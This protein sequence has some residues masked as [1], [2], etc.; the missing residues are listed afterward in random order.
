MNFEL[1]KQLLGEALKAPANVG[2]FVVHQL[3]VGGWA[4]FADKAV[5]PANIT[6]IS[7]DPEYKEAA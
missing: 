4:E 1:P 2:R 3:T 6:Y 7:T 5:Q